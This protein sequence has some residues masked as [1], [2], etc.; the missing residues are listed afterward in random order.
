MTSVP[1]GS[2]VLLQHR[3]VLLPDEAFQLRKD[4]FLID[5]IDAHRG[6]VHLS[7]NYVPGPKVGR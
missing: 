4:G 2:W 1:L 3:N 7:K 5:P 6:N